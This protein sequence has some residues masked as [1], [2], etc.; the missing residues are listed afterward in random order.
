MA[1]GGQLPNG[2]WEECLG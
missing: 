2:L 1:A